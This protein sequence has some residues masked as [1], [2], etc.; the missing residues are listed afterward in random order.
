M[1]FFL[2]ILIGFLMCI[3]VGPVNVWIINTKISEGGRPAVV[4]ALAGSLMD[5]IYIF[6][7]MSG[8]SLFHF[9]PK[10]IFFSNFFGVFVLISLGVK[11]LRKK[12]WSINFNKKEEPKKHLLKKKFLL[13]LF[14]YISNP[15]LI[16]TLT[17]LCAFLKSLSYF[18]TTVM[19]SLI[20][21]LGVGLGAFFWFLSL[22]SLI[23][24]FENK[25]TSV[26]LQRIN[27]ICGLIIMA[28]GLYLGLSLFKNRM[29]F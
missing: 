3:P 24:K 14:I 25:F 18:Q 10:F 7:I 13:G 16:V 11:E 20:F 6:F 21:A 12:N 19:N 1:A 27:V 17:A 28:F 29:I 22:I 9:S 5:F 8:L 23:N 26:I 2:G 15:T 4:L